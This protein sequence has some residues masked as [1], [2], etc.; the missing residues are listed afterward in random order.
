MPNQ[1][2]YKKLKI[3]EKMA[4]LIVTLEK[5]GWAVTAEMDDSGGNVTWVKKEA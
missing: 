5:L 1:E 2:E 3:S 4:L